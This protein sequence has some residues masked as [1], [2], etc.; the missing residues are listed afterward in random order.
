MKRILTLLVALTLLGTLCLSVSAETEEK[1]LV[2]L[3]DS[4]ATGHSLPDYNSSGNPKSL[5]SWS[6]LLAQ[7]YGAKQYNL[8]V[9]GD[10]VGDLIDVMMS[11]TAQSALAKA[12]LVCLSIGGNDFLQTM[13]A[14]LG[15]GTFDRERIEA[16]GEALLAQ[17]GAKLDTAFTTLKARVPEGTP[18]LT[19]TL[20]NPYRYFTVSLFDNL[21][22]GDWI[23][24][25]IDRFNATLK[26]KSA[27]HGILCVD[28]AATFAGEQGRSYLFDSCESGTP[29]TVLLAFSQSD[30]HPTEAGHRAIFDTYVAEAGAV[31]RAALSASQ[32]GPE[33]PTLSTSPDESA[34]EEPSET[35]TSDASSTDGAKEFPCLAIGVG[36]IAVSTLAILATKILRRRK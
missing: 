20:Y 27:D 23:G 9:D 10:T 2:I 28:V 15:S 1:N 17:I 33:K 12:D 30:P 14:A 19:Q 6:T 18:I 25:F 4:I 35:V 29:P 11:A 32:Q 8:A 3:G 22:I 26:Q 24:A 34:P 21:S 7:T 36:L 13:S 16:D 5:V 31:L